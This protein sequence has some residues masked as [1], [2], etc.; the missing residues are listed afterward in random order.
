MKIVCVMAKRFEIKTKSTYI[1]GT[2][3]SVHGKYLKSEEKKVEEISSE[4]RQKKNEED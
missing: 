2:S 1:D 3:M 4:D